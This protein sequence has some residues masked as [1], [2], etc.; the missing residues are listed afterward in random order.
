MK[1]ILITLNLLFLLGS[2][3]LY[4]QS[5]EGIDCSDTVLRIADEIAATSSGTKVGKVVR[6]FV[7]QTSQMGP[8]G[9]LVPKSE[10]DLDPIRPPRSYYVNLNFRVP[11]DQTG[12]LG[13][14]FQLR[15]SFQSGANYTNSCIPSDI[16]KIK[17]IR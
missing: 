12:R 7:M 16:S 15:I 5:S 17:V 14:S 4:A 3:D 9:T 10:T 8:N 13:S 1:F 6:K 2:I 11:G